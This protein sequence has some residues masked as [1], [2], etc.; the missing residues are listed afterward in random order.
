MKINHRDTGAQRR[1][2][3]IQF[4]PTLFCLLRAL[5]GE[6]L[7]TTALSV[8]VAE[9]RPA[10]QNEH[11]E[12]A[13]RLPRT[14]L[15][16]AN[17]THDPVRFAL[18]VLG[19]AFA[20]I[21]MFVQLG[22][23]NA[24]LDSNTQL[25]DKLRC[26]LVLVSPN[27]QAIA[28]VDSF[29]RRRLEQVRAVPGVAGVYPMYIDNALGRMRD[30]N[31]NP[32]DRG[33][34]RA[35]RSVGVDPDAFLLDVP[36]LDPAGDSARKLK[37]P[38]AVFVDR[39]TKADPDRPG[40]TLYGPLAEGTET[41]LSGSRVRVAGEVTLGTDF[42]CDGTLVMSDQTFIDVLRRPFTFPSDSPAANVD[43]G[44]V[45]LEAGADREAV[46]ADIRK[47]VSTGEADAD[48]SVY[49]LEELKEKE[50]TFWLNN[51]P[52]GFAFGFGT[53]MGFAVGVVI[54]YQILSGDVTDHLPQYATLKA[55]GYGNGYLAWVVLQ[56][57]LILAVLGF[58]VGLAVSWAAYE[59]LTA[60]TGMPLRMTPDRIAWVFAGTVAMCAASG[61]VALV[62]LLRADPADVF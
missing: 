20:V 59:V 24:L 29:P 23:R 44:L 52:I 15:A 46:M 10:V 2:D 33:P 18:Y 21:L 53:F 34:N 48:V 11:P 50:R 45:R 38:G 5:C 49:T 37:T 3:R 17:L 42:T 4:I 22:F 54:C 12:G 13:D 27:R 16:W 61:L 6:T 62:G 43:L 60:T 58:V 41:D 28:M 55:V 7:R 36:E 25:H 30:T 57:S 39:R 1:Q 56:E 40:Q 32:A 19:I 26:D 31:P 14:P 8:A 35:I 9:S 51:T 47:A